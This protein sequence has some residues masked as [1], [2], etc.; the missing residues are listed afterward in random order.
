MNLTSEFPPHSSS[1]WISAV[2]VFFLVALLAGAAV[3]A[4]PQGFGF[5]GMH[6]DGIDDAIYFGT[7]D[8]DIFTDSFE[9]EFTAVWADTHQRYAVATNFVSSPDRGVLLESNMAPSGYELDCSLF[10]P[11]GKV[12]VISD[13]ILP[14]VVYDFLYRVTVFKGIIVVAQLFQNSVEVDTDS[15]NGVIGESTAD[16][17]VGDFGRNNPFHGTI[18]GFTARSTP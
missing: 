13:P 17:V 12:S 14:G 3:A 8:N 10:L 5:R 4:E 2:L 7:S 9:I 16:F 18:S 1:F 15:R 6:F 11:S